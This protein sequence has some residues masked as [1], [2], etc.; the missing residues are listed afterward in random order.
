MVKSREIK[1]DKSCEKY[2]LEAAEFVWPKRKT[3]EDGDGLGE[4][5]WRWCAGRW[6]VGRFAVVDAE[7]CRKVFQRDKASSGAGA[8]SST[9]T[10]LEND[11]AALSC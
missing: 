5:G 1:D 3:F 10:P 4:G 9:S 7:G 8:S 6:K 2:V 11:L